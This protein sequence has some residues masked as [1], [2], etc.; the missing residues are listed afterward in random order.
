MFYL[1]NIFSIVFIMSIQDYF[2]IS[3]L[4]P[5]VQSNVIWN[6]QLKFNEEMFESLLIIIILKI[7]ESL[8]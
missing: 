7:I 3:S 1:E 6:I 4:L 2:Y 8:F 5:Q